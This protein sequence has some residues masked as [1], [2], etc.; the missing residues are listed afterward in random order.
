MNTEKSFM[1]L[2][3]I[4]LGCLLIVASIF[5][6]VQEG[7]IALVLRIGEFISDANN[8]PKVHRP[9][10]HLKAPIMDKVVRLSTKIQSINEQATRILTKEQ[11]PVEVD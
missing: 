9:G 2:S 7:Q 6:T 4:I 5:F 10:L 3:G 11:K 8:E 1:V